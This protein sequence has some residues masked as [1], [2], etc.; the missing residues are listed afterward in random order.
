[1]FSFTK[2]EIPVY[3]DDE[4][5][6]LRYLPYNKGLYEIRTV[7]SSE[8][9]LTKN[10]YNYAVFSKEGESILKAGSYI[11]ADFYL[12]IDT[13]R[14]T[15]SNR[16]RTSLFIV[17]DAA[18]TTGLNVSGYYLH[19]YDSTRMVATNNY[20][21]IASHKYSRANFVRAKRLSANQLQLPDSLNIS[22][23]EGTDRAQAINEYRF[24]LQKTEADTSRYYLVTE[25]GYGGR[26]D[27]TGYLSAVLSGDNFVYYFGPREGNNKLTVRLMKVNSIVANTVVPHP[28]VLEKLASKEISVTGGT[29]SMTV[30]NSLRKRV[31]V[32]NIVG[33]I[34]VDRILMSDNETFPVPRGIA[35][36]KIGNTITKKVVIR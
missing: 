10:F 34:V 28:A 29:G 35:I 31:M 16:F 11:P 17:K 22:I 36:V 30:L 1:L 21:E 12:W 32:Y 5:S 33:Q 19:V 23:G 24:Y 26:I 9:S 20:I 8:K 3:P 6:Y 4:Y 7:E 2:T 25:K 13:A 14:G 27:S 18:D 15:A